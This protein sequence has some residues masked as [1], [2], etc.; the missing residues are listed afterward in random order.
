MSEWIEGYGK[1]FGAGVA[2][3]YLGFVCVLSCL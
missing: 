1:C 3:L 2:I